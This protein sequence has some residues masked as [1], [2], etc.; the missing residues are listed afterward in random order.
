MV[1][2]GMSKS[3]EV[4]FTVDGNLRIVTVTKKTT[5]VDVIEKVCSKRRTNMAVF[6]NVVDTEK[7]LHG[8]TKIFKVWRNNKTPKDVKFTIKAV[9]ND[10]EPLNDKLSTPSITMQSSGESM[11]NISDLSSYVRYQ[12]KKVQLFK[13]DNTS[14][15]ADTVV[16]KGKNMWSHPLSN[17]MDAFLEKVDIDQLADLLSFC[18]K[19]TQ[20]KLQTENNKTRKLDVASLADILTSKRLSLKVN[21]TTTKKQPTRTTSTG[22]IES[23]DTGYHS[24]SSDTDKQETVTSR[25]TNYVKGKCVRKQLQTV[26]LDD[27]ENGPRH[28]TPVAAS[29]RQSRFRPDVD[30]TF[31]ETLEEQDEFRGKNLIMQRFMN[32]QSET[33]TSAV[34]V[35]SPDAKRQKNDFQNMPVA[36]DAGNLWK[37]EASF[38]PFRSEEMFGGEAPRKTLRRES[39]FTNLKKCTPSTRFSLPAHA[40]IS[41]SG[42]F[43]YSF[44]CSF[45]TM[46]E[47]QNVDFTRNFVNT[48]TSNV[49]TDVIRIN[50]RDADDLLNSFMKS[51]RS[52][53]D[54]DFNV[55]ACENNILD[56]NIYCV[57]E[58]DYFSESRA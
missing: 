52:Y 48:E 1:V 50:T 58:C 17:S 34:F 38:D 5:C 3:Q 39:A 54:D 40:Q 51:T 16:I 36:G 41:Q 4:P 30:C 14:D 28:S 44:N 27:D 23:T 7:E 21:F 53:C 2:M 26:L 20:K 37:I 55:T 19:I 12:T 49:I 22:T 15:A 8:K 42:P 46:D 31:T 43:D 45:P 32:D 25:K 47:H 35:S 13:N 24:L 33:S 57:D 6:M 10:E 18:D 9:H 56:A 11:K 29:R